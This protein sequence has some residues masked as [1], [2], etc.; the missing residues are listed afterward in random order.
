[1]GSSDLFS[2][3]GKLALVT[4]GARGIGLMISR[5]LLE[6]GARV[7]VAS[8]KQ[9]ALDAAAASLGALGHLETIRA[10]LST[11]DGVEAVA[12]RLS[13]RE[14]RL[15]ILVNNAGAM[16]A[17]PLDDYSEHGWDR[18]MDLNVKGVFFLCQK[19]A[20]LLRA[21]A[22]EASPARIV[23]IGSASGLAV[24]PSQAFAYAASK[25]GVHH[26]TRALAKDLAA[27]RITVNAIAPGPFATDMLAPA[28]RQ[29]VDMLHDVPLARF[30]EAD[31]IVGALLFLCSRA[32]AFVTGAVI[33]LDGGETTT[34]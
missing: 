5:G 14:T 7:V 11:L 18:V 27:D 1:M 22:S 13:A 29:G 34:M 9:D 26:L 32:G 33:P 20:P 3:E 4:G 17:A 30:G 19:L 28:M 6:A 21:A 2:V 24:R 10:D 15:D 31:D 12:E 16:W 23:N 8:R 25:A